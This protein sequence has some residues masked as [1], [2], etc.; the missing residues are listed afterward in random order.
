MKYYAAR[1]A[2]TGGLV[3]LL[4]LS[5]GC[6]SEKGS[7]HSDQAAPAPVITVAEAKRVFEQYDRTSAAADAALDGSAI[8]GVQTGVLLKE[9][10]AAYDIHH[11]AKT[12]DTVAHLTQPRFLIP[13]VDAAHTY[14]RYFA[15]LSKWKGNEDDRSSSLFYFTQTEA[16]SPWKA[17]AAG[18]AVTEP[19]TSPSPS[20]ATPTPSSTQ[21]GKTVRVEPKQLPELSQGASGTAHL[22]TTA[23]ADR[24]VCQSFADYLTF[25][26]P[27]GRPTDDRFTE[28]GFTSELVQHFNGWADKDL[29]R[30]MSYKTTGADLPVFR[31]ATGS[32]LVACTYI[33][34]HRVSGVGATG[35]VR[36]KK[37][38]DTDVLLG[39][40]G[41]EW[42]SV[43]ELS[44][45]TALIEVPTGNASP[46][47]VLACDCYAP[48]LVS[49][50]G[51]RP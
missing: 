49:A 40:G 46:A 39:D 21:D 8:R 42:R 12:A 6:T 16:K 22:S 27:N 38:S 34:E 33:R 36:F 23:P 41:R 45:M 13:A 5:A 37:R 48:Q 24:A 26:P 1:L 47:T 4:G 32:S 43:K 51:V 7:S 15:V 30:S 31:L 29:K 14:P 3:I 35:T 50:T 25:S 9:S 20:A 19:V 44:S 17:T 28:G 10:L 11:R 2:A 18:W